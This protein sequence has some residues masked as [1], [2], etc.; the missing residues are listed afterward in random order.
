MSKIK[1]EI[2][3][4]EV[5]VVSYLPEPSRVLVFEFT[6]E[7]DGYI[8]MGSQTSRI[9]GRECALDIRNIK[10]GEHLPR[11]V[12]SDRTIDLP[13]VVKDFS[14][15]RPKERSTDDIGELSLRERRLSRRV[16]EL[17][18]KLEE[19]SEMVYGRTIF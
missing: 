5:E 18:K 17:E 12:L 14:I 7:I 15:V 11:L 8:V 13:A 3:D 1:L 9:K 2:F 10:D 16:L 6:E 4:R 19:I